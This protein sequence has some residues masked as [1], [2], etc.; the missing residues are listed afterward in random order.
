[1]QSVASPGPGSGR[2]WFFEPVRQDEPDQLLSQHAGRLL[3]VTPFDPFFLM[4]GLFL[5]HANRCE[6]DPF[7][8][9]KKHNTRFEEIDTVLERAQVHW[10]FAESGEGP[11]PDDVELFTNEAFHHKHLSKIFV[12]LHHQDG[13]STLWR[14]DPER[15]LQ[16]IRRKIDQ[17]ATAGLQAGPESRTVWTRLACKEGLFNLDQTN[18]SL[19]KE[20]YQKVA[21]EM[22]DAHLP[23]WIG[24][25]VRGM[26]DYQFATLRAEAAKQDVVSSLNP[27]DIGRKVNPHGG[28]SDSRSRTSSNKPP[29]AKR[30]KND[31]NMKPKPKLTL[32]NF[33]KPPP[34]VS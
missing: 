16:E 29:P 14:L 17:L 1:M 10:L 19:M 33:F 27:L 30:K 20:M 24:E 28:P 23:P 25:H 6:T 3:L 26:D 13:G 31:E 21:L 7:E 4:L 22:V 5:G 34:P 9:E 15:I 32:D 12:P 8:V 18:V 2:T 11:V